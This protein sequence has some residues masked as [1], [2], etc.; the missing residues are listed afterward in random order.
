MNI[1]EYYEAECVYQDFCVNLQ[2]CDPD[3]RNDAVVEIVHKYGMDKITKSVR[4]L[5]EK[6][7]EDRSHY[8]ELL[9]IAHLVN[10]MENKRAEN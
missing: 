2:Y 6:L 4:V 8:L 9:R 3:K 5:C 1:N 7:D 10:R